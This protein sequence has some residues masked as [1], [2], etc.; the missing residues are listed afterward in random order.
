MNAITSTLD[1]TRSLCSA[2]SA[3]KNGPEHVRKT[4]DSLHQF[5][6]QLEQ[7]KRDY[8][9]DTADGSCEHADLLKSVGSSH[10]DLQEFFSKLQKLQAVHGENATIKTWKR[11]RTVVTEKDLDSIATKIARHRTEITMQLNIIDG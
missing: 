8:R 7:I 11:L 2:I 1:L 3:I 4:A 10:S 9:L 5:A 6:T